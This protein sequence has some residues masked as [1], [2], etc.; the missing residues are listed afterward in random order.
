LKWLGWSLAGIVAVALVVVAGVYALSEHQLRKVYAEV[1]LKA[2]AVPHNPEA[3][4]KGKR[5]ATLY[6]CFNSC[7]GSTLQGM[8]L[9]DEPGIARINAPNLTRIVP[10]YSDAELE[11][12]LRHGVKKDGTST[13]IMPSPMF[14]RLSDEDLANII[15]F[16]RTAP[17]LDGP[18]REVSMGPLGRLGIVI[19]KFKPLATTIP[20]D[21]PHVA[22]TDRADSRA[23][24]EYMVMT[25][26][27]ECHGQD[28]KGDDFLKAPGLEV[29]AGY[30]QAA[31]RRLMKTGIALGD[32]KLGLM[33]EVSE[34]R[35]PNF[36]EEELTAVEGYLR[37]TFGGPTEDVAVA[38][39]P[40][41]TEPTA[42]SASPSP[43]DRS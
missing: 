6:G 25:T 9:F 19:G 34:T 43:A 29:T 33:T 10:E 8:K 35:F 17:V 38:T 1:P 12:L 4:A 11:R 31:F 42:S 20:A 24:G 14:S 28:L 36:T 15:A 16:V 23:F 37:R 13:W 18:M 26:C 21:R 39:T 2:F 27:T 22:K 7:H 5:L 30:S 32:R 3:I 40:S 41:E